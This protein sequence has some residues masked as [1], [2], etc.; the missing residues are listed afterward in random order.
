V[1]PPLAC[2]RFEPCEF[3]ERVGMIVDSEVEE[4][5]RLFAALVAAGRIA[6]VHGSDQSPNGQRQIG[7]VGI[8]GF[9]DHLTRRRDR[10]QRDDALR[11]VEG[12]ARRRL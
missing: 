2:D 10:V 6:R 12:L 5:R 9:L 1:D 4:R 11:A 8:G 7:L 3:G